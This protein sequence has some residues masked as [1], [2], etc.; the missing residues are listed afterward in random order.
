MQHAGKPFRE[1]SG[2]KQMKIRNTIACL[3]YAVSLTAFAAPDYAT[4]KSSLG[5][6]KDEM[7]AKFGRPDHATDS[8]FYPGGHWYYKNV[9]HPDTGTTNICAV[10][11]DSDLKVEL[12]KC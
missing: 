9:I 12:V 6:S 1:T 3:L 7:R 5:M 4:I 11:F 8:A 2:E 10:S